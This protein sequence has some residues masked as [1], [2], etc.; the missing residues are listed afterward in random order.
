MPWMEPGTERYILD[1]SSMD[2]PL[3]R[4]CS[5]TRLYQ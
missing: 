5:S 2:W 3:Y 1:A 4:Q